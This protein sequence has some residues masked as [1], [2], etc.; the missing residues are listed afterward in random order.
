MSTPLAPLLAPSQLLTCPS[1][2][3]KSCPCI[4]KGVGLIEMLS[5]TGE[6]TT[7]TTWRGRE[8]AAL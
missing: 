8:G 6:G 3:P 1:Y 5:R 2:A 4:P 7:P